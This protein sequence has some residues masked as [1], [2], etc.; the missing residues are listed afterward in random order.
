M[1]KKF[2]NI[3]IDNFFSNPDLIRKY[4]LSLEYH[5]SK[6][7][8]WPGERSN[9]LNIINE[10]LQNLILA[11]VFAAYYPVSGYEISF[12]D[13]YLQFQKIKPYSN[14]KDSLKNTGWIHCDK[15]IVGGVIY[16][17]PNPNPDSGTSLYDL[18]DEFKDLH[19]DDLQQTE[20]HN[21][22]MGR[23]VKDYDERLKE[24]NNKFKVKTIFKN[25]YNRMIMYSGS[26]YHCANN[27][28]CDNDRLTLAFFIKK[29]NVKNTPIDVI[30]GNIDKDIESQ[31]EHYKFDWNDK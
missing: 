30:K 19:N 18:K 7:G 21:L 31:L 28:Y 3:C 6:D 27:F 11:K 9:T 15:A 2:H 12:D 25:V 13:T 4:A 23:F 8:S 14:D 22:H 10:N 16:L 26:E 5:R 29:L 20:K 17:T 24:H 1:I